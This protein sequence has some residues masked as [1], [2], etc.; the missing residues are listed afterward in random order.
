MRTLTYFVGLFFAGAVFADPPTPS[1]IVANPTSDP[2]PVIVQGAA[3]S[4]QTLVEYRYVGNTDATTNGAV[5]ESL[6]GLKGLARLNEMCVAEFGLSARV[7]TPLE[8]SAPPFLTTPVPVTTAWVHSRSL[9]V[10]SQDDGLIQA[11]DSET[12]VELLRFPGSS[13]DGARR[14]PNCRAWTDRLSNNI[15]GSVRLEDG[16]VTTGGCDSVIHVACSAQVSLP[17]T[18]LP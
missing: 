16:T 13:R 15:H 12:G 14:V 8:A 11:R 9:V 18:S 6:P 7:S 1:V 4:A 5:G 2:V 3:P 17:A 10:E